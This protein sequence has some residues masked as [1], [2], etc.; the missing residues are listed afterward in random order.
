MSD[1]PSPEICQRILALWV[2]LG[3]PDWTENDR[4]RL[5][6]LLI[7]H[8]QSVSDLPQI[9]HAAGVIP[10]PS[11]PKDGLYERLWRF[12]CHLNV[13]NEPTRLEARKK[14]DALLNEHNLEW[15]GPNGFTAILIAYW[16]DSNNIAS[17]L[18]HRRR[19][20]ATNWN[21]TRSI[22][23]WCCSKTIRSCRRGIG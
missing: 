4:H 19:R 12:F 20:R 6:N 14:L 9:F 16:A 22:L 10:A 2:V 21:S 15:N 18:Q 11:R 8:G 23:C 17:A 7:Q 5:I 3:E 13:D 1:L